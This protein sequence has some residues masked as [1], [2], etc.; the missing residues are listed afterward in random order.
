VPAEQ[1]EFAS[2]GGLATP[3]G[4]S[5][6]VSIPAGRLVW[7]A[8]QV[9]LDADRNIVA[10]GDWEGQTRRVF[11]NLSLALRAAGAGWVDV[12]KLTLFVVDVSELETIRAVRDEFVNAT[13]PPTS[14]LVRVA[15]LFHLDVLIEVEAVAW[16]PS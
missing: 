14:T 3:A 7:T 2:P 4:Y 13:S 16:L 5:H 6:V 15:G 12:V 8:G 1:P 11:E 9:P 10:A